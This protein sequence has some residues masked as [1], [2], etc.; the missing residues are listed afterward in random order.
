MRRLPCVMVDI[1]TLGIRP[2][3]K[4]LSIGACRFS[5]NS[6]SALNNLREDAFYA[7]IDITEYDNLPE[8]TEDSSTIEWWSK[9]SD[10][11]VNAL[12]EN[13]QSIGKALMGFTGWL[14]A[15]P[16]ELIWANSPSFDLAILSHHFQVFKVPRPWAYYIERDVRTLVWAAKFI[17]NFVP[18][19]SY[20]ASLTE[21]NALDDAIAQTLMLQD[22]IFNGY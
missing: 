1:E 2:T 10:A 12:N 14:K 20:G 17:K 5:L 22:A 3:S 21:H 11:A 13:Q 4:M 19:V 7:N 6:V 8:F 15:S 18:A 9:Q 16:V